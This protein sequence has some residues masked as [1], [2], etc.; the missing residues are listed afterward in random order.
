MPPKT[1]LSPPVITSLKLIL[2]V[3]N[4]Y[5][6][7][8]LPLYRKSLERRRLRRGKAKNL[9]GLRVKIFPTRRA[10]AIDMPPRVPLSPKFPA[11]QP[12]R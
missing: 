4:T 3:S 12:S 11:T 10:A 2:T 8:I 7:K 6:A 1:G 9:K 5:Y